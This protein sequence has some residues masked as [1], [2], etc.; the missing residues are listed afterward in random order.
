MALPREILDVQTIYMEPAVETYDRGR[1][2]LERYP[3]ARRIIVSSH[4]A[5]PTLYGNEGNAEDCC[6]S[7]N[8]R[9]YSASRR[10]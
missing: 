10:A 1:Q 8:I 4:N 6:G 9:W 3:D 2:V 5:I 7:S